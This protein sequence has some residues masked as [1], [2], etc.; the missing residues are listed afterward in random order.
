MWIVIF[1]DNI[2]HSAWSTR[3]EAIQQVRVLAENGYIRLDHRSPNDIARFVSY[4][5]T[6]SCENGHYYV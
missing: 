5:A 6:V 1:G 2:R 4:D 3:R